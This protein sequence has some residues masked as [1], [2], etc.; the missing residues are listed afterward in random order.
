M[1]GPNP[2]TMAVMLNANYI[3]FFFRIAEDAPMGE[4]GSRQMKI[5]R[6]LFNSQIHLSCCFIFDDDFLSAKAPCDP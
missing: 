4:D 2:V 6:G 5:L 3:C 1:N